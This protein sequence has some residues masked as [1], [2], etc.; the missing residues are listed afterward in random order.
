MPPTKKF[1]KEDIIKAS[2]QIILKEGIDCVNARRIAKELGCSI[3]PIFHNFA[4]MKELNKAIYQQ[5]YQQYK[6]YMLPSV[7]NNYP[8]KEIGLSYIRFARDFPAFFKMIFM[9]ETKLNI[10]EFIMTDVVGESIIKTGQE[11]T[12]LSFDEQKYFHSKVWIF[13]HG[14]ACLVATKTIQF[15]EKDISD[16]LGNSVKEMLIGYKSERNV[17]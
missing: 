9:Q 5:V 16:L 15:S 6:D 2:C 4:S 3:Q 10:E 11:L 8:Y 12:G 17:S 1:S 13:T 14:L 7:K